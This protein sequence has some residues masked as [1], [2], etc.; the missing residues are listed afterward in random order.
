M[1][2]LAILPNAVFMLDGRWTY[3]LEFIVKNS[4]EKCSVYDTSPKT[5]STANAAKQAM[6]EQIR[7][8]RTRHGL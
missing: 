7:F 6:R 1:K 4:K 3:T 5:F 8:E 2:I